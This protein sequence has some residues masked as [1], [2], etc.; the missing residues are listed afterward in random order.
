[1]H[2]SNHTRQD[3]KL[4]VIS[5]ELLA[6]LPNVYHIVTYLPIDLCVNFL[7]N[8]P[9]INAPLPAPLAHATLLE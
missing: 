1:M 2:Q 9:L 5:H 6:R 7:I 8:A 3:H 4:R